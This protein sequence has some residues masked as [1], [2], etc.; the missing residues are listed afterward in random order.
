MRRRGS[1]NDFFGRGPAKPSD[2]VFLAIA[3]RVFQLRQTGQIAVDGG[4]VGRLSLG[5]RGLGIDHVGRGGV[6]V[7]IVDQRQS[8]VFGRLGRGDFAQADAF[9]IGGNGLITDADLQRDLVQHHF[10]AGAGGGDA[11]VAAADLALVRPPA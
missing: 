5:Q 2:Q 8:Q 3:Q 10:Q 9:Q 1:A 11:G 4:R 6:A 7:L